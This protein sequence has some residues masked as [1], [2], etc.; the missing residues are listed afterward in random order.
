MRRPPAELGS[1][2]SVREVVSGRLARLEPA[3]SDLL[4]LASTAGAEFELEMVRRASGLGEAELVAALDEAVRSGLVEEVPAHGLAWRFTHELVRRALY[5]RLSAVRRAELHLRVGEALEAGEWRSGRALADL[6]HHFSAA[7]PFGGAE[8]AVEYN[9]LAA[10]AAKAALAFGEASDR[11]RTALRLGVDEPRRRAELLLELGEVSNR[12]GRAPDA[13]EA[14]QTAAGIA[15]DLGDAELLARGA[16]GY[17]DACWRPGFHDQGAVELLEEAVEALG[18]EDCGLR[19]RLLSGLA[20]A[21]DFQGR[22]EEGV[23][24]RTSAIEMARRLGDREALASVL[25]RAYWSRGTT[26][27]D[28]ILAMLTEARD[29]AVEL[30]DTELR[31]EAMSWRVTTFVALL[32]LASARR[33]WTRSARSPSRRRS[34]SSSTWPS[35]TAP[36]SPSATAGSTRRRPTRAA[37]RNGRAC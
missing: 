22:R 7:A 33:R 25:V 31:A 15:R 14:F 18:E 11:L 16:T 27:L 2:E 8:R 6:A 26:P 32:D 20:R 17:E 13:L 36:R 30:G 12:G 21:L 1:P 4:E 35:T 9:V 19:V 28:E 29:I 34:R 5:D 10:R 37:P 24:A 23:T 3:T